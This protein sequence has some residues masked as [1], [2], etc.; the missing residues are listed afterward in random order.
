MDETIYLLSPSYCIP[1]LSI[2][3]QCNASCAWR[4]HLKESSMSE[5][6]MKTRLLLLILFV[7]TVKG[8]EAGSGPDQEEIG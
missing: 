8:A 6:I 5:M 1:V 4:I 3:G 7:N 2:T